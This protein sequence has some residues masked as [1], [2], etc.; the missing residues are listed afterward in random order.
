L[1]LP[2]V[3]PIYLKFYKFFFPRSE[4]FDALQE[5]AETA[6]F[7]A[8]ATQIVPFCFGRVLDLGC[9]FGYLTELVANKENVSE[10]VAIDKIPPSEFRFASHPKISYLQRDLTK[11]AES[12]PSFDVI[13]ASE[14]IEH[15]SEEDFMR[16]LRWI[17]KELKPGGFFVGST[18]Y[19][20]TSKPKF[21]DS[22]FHVREYQPDALKSI[23][24]KEGFGSVQLSLFDN[25]F[26]WCA[27]L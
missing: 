18:P 25:F 10:V 23:I 14:F 6:Y 16:L 13:V 17:K 3:Q 9:G 15:I 20:R 12:L 7:D 24:L 19:N 22:P 21:S 26:I 1:A 4:R 2:L 8:Y 11:I 27:R 5:G